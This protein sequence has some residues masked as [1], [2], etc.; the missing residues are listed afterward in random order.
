MLTLIIADNKAYRAERIAAAVKEYAPN[1]IIVLDDT[2]MTITDLEQY[3]YPSLFTIGTPMVHARFIFDAKEK[4]LAPTLLKNMIASPTM[5]LFE[6]LALSKPF[7]T[8]LKKQGAIIHSDPSSAKATAGKESL[9]S[10]AAL[11][12]IVGKKDRWLAYQKAIAQFPIEAILGMVYWKT[13]DMALKEN[14]PAGGQGKYHLLYTAL[15]EAH[16][17]A[18]QEGT[19]LE[20]AIE[21]VLLQ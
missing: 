6:E 19:P 2:V 5:F 12:T 11:V 20:L 7:I 3:L 21:K 17:Q 10:V 8:N 4:D 9:F 15:L 16:A 14:P 1:E 13:R 18:W